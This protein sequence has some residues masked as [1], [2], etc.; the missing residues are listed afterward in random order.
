M[1]VVHFLPHTGQ[2]PSVPLWTQGHTAGADTGPLL[3]GQLTLQTAAPLGPE[4][5]ALPLHNGLGL[6]REFGCRRCCPPGSS[7][8]WHTDCRGCDPAGPVTALS[9]SARATVIFSPVSRRAMT[10]CSFSMSLGPISTRTGTPFISYSANF[11]P[12]ELSQSS[13]LT[14]HAGRLQPVQQSWRAASS[15][16]GL[17]G[18][19]GDDHHLDGGDAG[20]AA[21]GRCRRRGS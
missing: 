13:I 1:S 19:H 12:G 9:S 15:T 3:H 7:G 2:V 11:Q 18:G 10:H 14:P 20:E 21:P 16:P 17:C 4:E 6:L 8:P 5:A